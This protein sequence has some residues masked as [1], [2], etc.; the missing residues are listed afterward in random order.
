[1]LRR[2]PYGVIEVENGSFKAVYFRPWPKLVSV[3]EIPWLGLGVHQRAGGDRI[4]LYFNQPRRH[5]TFLTLKY[6]ISTR[7][8]TLR[9]FRAVLAVLDEV[10]R[11]KKSDA[12]LCE[13]RNRRISDRLFERWGWEPHVPTSRYRHFIK[14]FY[15]EYP[16]FTASRSGPA[17]PRLLPPMGA[18]FRFS[19]LWPARSIDS[20]SPLLVCRS[21][22]VRSL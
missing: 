11:V 21:M 10:A 7:R 16:T 15:G 19:L 6:V 4:W 22:C 9:S 3:A 8:A 17:S 5:R 12:I 14:R 18:V 20:I 1:M 13:A 2:R